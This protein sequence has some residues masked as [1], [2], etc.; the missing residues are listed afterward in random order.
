MADFWKGF[1]GGFSAMQGLHN[2]RALQE[3]RESNRVYR[4]QQMAIARE[5][6]ARAAEL[7]PYALEQNKAQAEGAKLQL[8]LDQRT[9]DQTQYT[10]ALRNAFTQS[11][12]T[13]EGGEQAPA[14]IKQLSDNYMQLQRHL[15]TQMDPDQYG[16]LEPALAGMKS[17][18]LDRYFKQNGIDPTD[19]ANDQL[20]TKAHLLFTDPTDPGFK[21][22]RDALDVQR[23]KSAM[24][25]AHN[26]G[27]TS[28]L[29]SMT[30]AYG[31]PVKEIT[32]SPEPVKSR[33][34]EGP[35]YI[36]VMEDGTVDEISQRELL[37]EHIYPLEEASKLE[38]QL[39]K[40]AKE[41]YAA[42]NEGREL[43]PHDA[44]KLKALSGLVADPDT[45][46]KV[47]EDAAAMIDSMRPAAAG[48]SGG[49]GF[50]EYAQEAARAAQAA[51]EP[52][53]SIAELQAGYERLPQ[54][55]QGG[56]NK[57]AAPGLMRQAQ[58]GPTDT[59]PAPKDSRSFLA[60]RA[61]DEQVATEELDFVGQM[62]DKEY[63]EWYERNKHALG[64]RQR[65]T[66]AVNPAWY[67]RGQ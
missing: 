28:E 51:G 60:Q 45:D 21:A 43:D 22:T 24:Q 10:D 42:R 5:Q 58:T 18:L 2:A 46:P 35:G 37:L 49:G 30:R 62:S 23:V 7:H 20:M 55:A 38:E 3:E 4:E 17:Q 8:G 61:I 47:R 26:S 59:Q 11:M 50:T 1:S 44:A 6:A 34:G 40:T 25:L 15:R 32:V 64:L 16:K 13:G 9:V 52:I 67:G 48:L 53:P 36:V 57:A 39:N 31:M 56:N 41:G 54:P 14:D 66:L 19:R 33:Y 63:A 65:A 27:D 29:L 12:P